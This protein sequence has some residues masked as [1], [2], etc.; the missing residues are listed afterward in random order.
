MATWSSTKLY[1]QFNK[2]K[3]VFSTNDV[4]ITGHSYVK[5]KKKATTHTSHIAQKFI[6]N[7]S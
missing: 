3:M 5:K 4:G 7:G 1:E 2:E 6:Q